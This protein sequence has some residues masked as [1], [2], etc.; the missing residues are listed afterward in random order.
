[1]N[2]TRATLGFLF[3][4]GTSLWVPQAQGNEEIE[5]F[6]KARKPL[7]SSQK[8]LL[9]IG[10]AKY[11]LNRPWAAIRCAGSLLSD[12]NYGSLTDNPEVF[13]I[14]K[15]LRSRTIK[16]SAEHSFN[17]TNSDSS[18]SPICDLTLGVCQGMTNLD[19]R[20]NM[21]VYY[22]PENTLAQKVPTE[23]KK[24]FRFYED[25]IQKTREGKPVVV[26]GFN[27]LMEMSQHPVMGRVLR[28]AVVKT[29]ASEN[30]TLPGILTVL[31]SIRGSFSAKEAKDLHDDLKQRVARHYNPIIYLSKSLSSARRKWIHILPV[32]AV[33]DKAEDGSYQV[34]IKDP[35]RSPSHNEDFLTITKEGKATF[36]GS[37]LVEVDIMPGDDSEIAQFLTS[38]I[39]FCKDERTKRFCVETPESPAMPLTPE[40]IGSG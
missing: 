26:P 15:L 1:M 33:S 5:K 2:R 23:P 30:A 40:Q 29:W 7:A 3:L 32:H 22:D 34:S 6:L 35:N 21:L 18:F 17:F 31:T 19:R 11:L 14:F 4:F 39:E 37:E 28:E 38:T 16:P 13:E 20:L 10:F 36:G 24:L 12:S 9:A 27:N 8:V 25:L